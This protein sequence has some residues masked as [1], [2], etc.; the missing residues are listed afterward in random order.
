MNPAPFSSRSRAPATIG[1]SGWSA[2]ILA[3]PSGAATT[4]TNTIDV[5]F[6]FAVTTEIAALP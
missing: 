6:A 1:T 5:G 4:H 2:S 3:T